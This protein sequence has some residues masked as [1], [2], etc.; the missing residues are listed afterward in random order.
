MVP[1][2]YHPFTYHLLNLWNIFFKVLMTIV[3]LSRTSMMPYVITP[4][5]TEIS[6][7]YRL[8][9]TYLFKT[10]KSKTRRM[11]VIVAV[12]IKGLTIVFAISLYGIAFQENTMNKVDITVSARSEVMAAPL[13]PRKPMERK[14][15]PKLSKAPMM[16]KTVVFDILPL[17]T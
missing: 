4:T 13:A 5:R 12:A 15:A 2:N 7:I 8:F 9:M 6:V 1:T 16:K 3:S 10:S 11:A 17:G 14:F